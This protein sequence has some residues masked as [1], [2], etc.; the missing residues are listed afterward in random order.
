MTT[1][2]YEAGDLGQKFRPRARRWAWLPVLVLSTRGNLAA[3]EDLLLLRGVLSPAGHAGLDRS[4][5]LGVVVDPCPAMETE[6]T[7]RSG[8]NVPS[9][10]RVARHLGR[11]QG[12][13]RLPRH[14]SDQFRPAAASD[15]P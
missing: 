4:G 14:R 8:R 13:V 5:G 10:G 6:R 9:G 15:P 12:P 7:G 3:A 1:Q 11:L 2:R